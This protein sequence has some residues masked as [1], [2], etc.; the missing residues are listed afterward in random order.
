MA[1][2][3][4]PEAKEITRARAKAV[5][6]LGPAP[7]TARQLTDRLRKRGFEAEVVA[8]VVAECIDHG[9]IDDADYA[10]RWCARRREQGYGRMRIRAELHQRGIAD[11]VTAAALAEEEAG[12]E[13]A[14]ARIAGARKL[15]SL[16]TLT[17]DRDRAKLA[18]F[19]ATRGFNGPTARR[20]V[21][22]VG[23]A[24]EPEVD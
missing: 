5:R 16:G 21:E 11:G 9:W 23:E 20:V 7:L 3:D 19:L 15:K 8:T 17:T 22:E 1:E 18:R 14:A 4:K 24:Q 6:L 2:T 13:L 10:R 12:A